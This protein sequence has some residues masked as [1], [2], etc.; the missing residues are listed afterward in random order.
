MSEFVGRVLYL[1]PGLQKGMSSLI[2]V[3]LCRKVRNKCR[4][5]QSGSSRSTLAPAVWA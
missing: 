2:Q 5:V 4:T 1:G 3:A